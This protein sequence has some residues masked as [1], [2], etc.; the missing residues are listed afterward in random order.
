M[1]VYGFSCVP[2]AAL[3]KSKIPMISAQN[4]AT[5]MVLLEMVL[6]RRIELPTPSLP[7][8]CGTR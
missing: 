4:H 3:G 2:L 1:S 8:P 7:T 5:G 6:L